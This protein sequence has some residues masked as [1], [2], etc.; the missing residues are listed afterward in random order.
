LVWPWF[1]FPKAV[2]RHHRQVIT[3]I[4]TAIIDIGTVIHYGNHRHLWS[5]W[6]F[7]MVESL[8]IKERWLN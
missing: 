2:Y 7:R 4:T 1:F 6:P 3:T 5:N 8:L